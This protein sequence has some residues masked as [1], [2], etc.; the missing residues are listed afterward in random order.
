M[1]ISFMFP[2]KVTVR[3]VCQTNEHHAH[4]WGRGEGGGEGGGGKTD[5]NVMSGR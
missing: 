3:A 1:V 5:A 2:D 4:Y